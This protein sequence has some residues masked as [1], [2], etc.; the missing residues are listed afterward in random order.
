MFQKAIT[1]TSKGTFTLPAKVRKELGLRRAGDKLT[2][3]YHRKSQVV[4]ITKAPD[5]KAMQAEIAELLPSHLKGKPFDLNE[6]RR[7]KHEAYYRDHCA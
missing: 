3:R 7:Q 4:E 6:I 2:L 1:M 5:L